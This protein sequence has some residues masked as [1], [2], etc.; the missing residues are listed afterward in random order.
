M[1]SF[2]VYALAAV[3]EI[4]GCYAFWA[5]LRLGKIALWL[6]PGMALLALFA[7]ALTLIEVNAAA[8]LTRRLPLAGSGSARLRFA[9]HEGSCSITSGGRSPLNRRVR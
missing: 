4:A 5:W 1:R 2:G 7:Y 3:A 6:I 9:L 8:V